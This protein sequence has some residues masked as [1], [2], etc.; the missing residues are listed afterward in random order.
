MIDAARWSQRVKQLPA[1]VSLPFVFRFCNGCSLPLHVGRGICTPA[2]Q[3]LDVIDDL[4]LT[5]MRLARGAR[6][7]PYELLF[8][9]GAAM[10][11]A[12]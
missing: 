6:V 1:T 4:P 7:L 3:R 9:R 5:P 11:S 12:A 10:D 2:G 8:S